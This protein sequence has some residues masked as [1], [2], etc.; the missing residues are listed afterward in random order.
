MARVFLTEVDPN[1]ERFPWHD[2]YLILKACASSDRFNQHV[3]CGSPDIADVIL[4]ADAGAK[5]AFDVLKHPLYVRC[6]DKFFAYSTTDYVF[7]F[8]P[9][10][11]PS[12]ARPDHDPRRT[13]SGS[14]IQTVPSEDDSYKPMYEH[15]R[16]LFSFVGA[17]V[18][19]KVRSELATLEHPDYLFIDTSSAV[20]RREGQTADVYDKYK[21]YYAEI[22]NDSKFVLCPRGV[23]PSSL[24][25]FETMRSGR[26]PVIITDEW[27]EPDGPDWQHFSVRVSERDVSQIP[28]LIETLEDRAQRMGGL[29]R[30]A[31]C[32]WFAKD[33]VF[34]RIVE[35]C[36][37]MK[38]AR[39]S[40]ERVERW[41]VRRRLF[42]PRHFRGSFLRGLKYRVVSR[43]R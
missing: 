21:R 8:I 5:T 3:L 11:Y 31:W 40:S 13:R 35:A 32:K 30:E 12:I 39:L 28:G 29:A 2:S 6:V 20:A 36:I 37:A 43:E 4:C 19:C 27:V 1:H 15:S 42:T 16:Y 38:A 23:G 34:H 26:V 41:L 10:V 17:A 18:T 22:L 7:P 33:V 9:G 14:Y 25:L 24:R